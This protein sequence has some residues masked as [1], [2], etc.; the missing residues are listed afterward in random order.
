MVKNKPQIMRM[1]R[2]VENNPI[3]TEA[4]I[5]R[6][7][8]IEYTIRNTADFEIKFDFLVMGVPWVGG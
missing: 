2:A 6:V 8:Q 7:V 3:K 5:S 4:L 1:I